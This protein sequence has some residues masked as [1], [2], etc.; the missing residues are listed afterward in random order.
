MTD[1]PQR[2]SRETIYTCPWF[3]LHGDRVRMPGGRVLDRYHVLGFPR[4]AAAA[5]VE[6]DEGRILLVQAYRYALDRVQWEVPA[7]FMEPG[8][9]PEQAALRE[10]EEETGHACHG[11]RLLY[12]FNPLSGLADQ[13]FHV[14]QTR[15]TGRVGAFDESEVAA[16]RW[17]TRAEV[18]ALVADGTLVDGFSL[19]ALLLWLRNGERP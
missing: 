10:A 7:G 18:D 12:A 2:L 1:K 8:E 19:T 3:T 4:Q 14:V 5:L 11:S 13:V 16:W 9:T 15:A 6:D 17:F